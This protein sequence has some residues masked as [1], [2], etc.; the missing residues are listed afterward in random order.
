[1]AQALDEIPHELLQT[2]LAQQ[3]F[4]TYRAMVAEGAYPDAQHIIT[5]LEDE[6][7]KNVMTTLD[8]QA[9]DRAAKALQSAEDRLASVISRLKAQQ[10]R[11]ALKMVYDGRA[12]QEDALALVQRAIQQQREKI[13]K[14]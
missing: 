1:V 5:E 13:A 6:R 11:A 10:D 14:Q 4:Q 12:S 8:W 9:H 3:L 7:L 2:S